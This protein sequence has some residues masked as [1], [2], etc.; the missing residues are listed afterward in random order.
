MKVSL[1]GCGNVGATFANLVISRELCDE[2]CLFDIFKDFVKAKEMDLAQMGVLLQS[3][4]KVTL[5][6]TY[7]E[8]KDSSVVV[9]TAGK[10]RKDGMT[11]ED[12]L[13]SN[14]E[15]IK[16]VGQNIAK[17][18]PDAIIII[19]TNPLDEMVYTAFKASGFAKNRVLGMAGELDSARLIYHISKICDLEKEKINAKVIGPHNDNMLILKELITPDIGENFDEAKELTKTTGATITKLA[20][21]SAFYGPAAGIFKMVKAIKE[22]SDEVLSCCVLD[23][24]EIP[25]GRLVTLDRNGVKEILKYEIDTSSNNLDKIFDNLKQNIALLDT[26]ILK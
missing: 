2:I 23:D 8:L 14:G 12:L 11:R 10:P 18:A 17:Y 25:F 1:I 21:A 13:I 26:N 6:N 16:E 3:K 20:K 4:T 7:E 24:S 9:V 19:V 22:Q 15:V 5:G